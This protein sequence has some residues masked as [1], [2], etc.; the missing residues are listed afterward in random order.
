MKRKIYNLNGSSY[1]RTIFLAMCISRIC[2]KIWNVLEKLKFASELTILLICKFLNFKGIFT[3]KIIEM[4]KAWTLV[5]M[6]ES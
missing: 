4:I 3:K 2:T 1:S 5:F 6:W